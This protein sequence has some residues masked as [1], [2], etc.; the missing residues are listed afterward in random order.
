MH[1]SYQHICFQLQGTRGKDGWRQPFHEALR[2]LLESAGWQAESQPDPI[3]PLAFQKGKQCLMLYPDALNG[4]VLKDT[5][6]DLETLLRSSTVFRVRKADRRG[7]YYAM[8]D[9]SYWSYLHGRRRKFVAGILRVCRTEKPDCFITNLEQVA[10]RVCRDLIFRRLSD[11]GKSGN[12]AYGYVGELVLELIGQ[13]RLIA[14]PTRK[15]LGIRT[16]TH[17]ERANARRTAAEAGR[18]KEEAS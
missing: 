16:A 12:L 18:E 2:G 9:A 7:V 15:G 8:D 3:R 17:A 14:E 4:L 1:D 10:D 6:P 11:W 5:L 13:G